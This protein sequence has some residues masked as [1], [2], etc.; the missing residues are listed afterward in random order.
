VGLADDIRQRLRGPYRSRQTV[1]G[2]NFPGMNIGRQPD[3]QLK[4][5]DSAIASLAEAL[6]L[7]AE[8]V[9]EL[10]VRRGD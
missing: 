7:I 1:A 3:A 2:H 4:A 9:D 8:R 10:E 5:L 6:I